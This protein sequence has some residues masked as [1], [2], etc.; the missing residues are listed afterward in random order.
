MSMDNCKVIEREELVSFSSTPYVSA[1]LIWC[2]RKAPMLLILVWSGKGLPGTLPTLMLMLYRA[3][4][5]DANSVPR[6]WEYVERRTRQS[7][8]VHGGEEIDGVGIIAILEKDEG[9]EIVLVKQF[10]PAM[11]KT[12]V[13][14]PA[15]LV[16]K[17]ERAEDTAI[18]EL[19]EETGYVGVVDDSG[20]VM[21]NSEIQF[22]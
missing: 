3:T 15:G 4:Y 16:D 20:P 13:E 5:L 6:K 10:R 7:A 22:L 2:T 11:D 1:Y 19:K 14:V 21:W 17:G 12:C 9:P 8:K 18:R